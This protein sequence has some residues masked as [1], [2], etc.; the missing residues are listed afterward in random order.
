V[1]ENHSLEASVG[2]GVDKRRVA[3]EEISESRIVCEDGSHTHADSTGDTGPSVLHLMPGQT[4]EQKHPQR[5]G[6]N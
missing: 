1:V 3:G 2:V 6:Q 4:Q 5:D